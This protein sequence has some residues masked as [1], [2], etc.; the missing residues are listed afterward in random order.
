ML[1]A[2]SLQSIPA[3]HFQH[4][5]RDCP[6]STCLY[7]PHELVLVCFCQPLDGALLEHIGE[8]QPVPGV[9]WI[10]QFVFQS[11]Q[12]LGRRSE[13]ADALEVGHPFAGRVIQ[14]VGEVDF[15]RKQRG[16][17]RSHADDGR[18]LAVEEQHLDPGSLLDHPS[19]VRLD[20]GHPV[21]LGDGQ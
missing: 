12:A 2:S 9:L 15:L 21:H 20:G 1:L 7:L 3:E 19:D 14:A 10:A 17:R 18:S 13:E 4:Y 16:C 8:V 11:S 5:K 6:S